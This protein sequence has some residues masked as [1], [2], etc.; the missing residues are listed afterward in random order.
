MS[1]SMET[2]VETNAG[3]VEG[4]QQ[5][6]LCVFKGIPY[7]APPVGE[8]RWLPPAMVEPWSD[9]C[10]AKSSAAICPQS[11]AEGGFL[12]LNQRPEA[13][14]QSEDCLYLNVWTPALD[15]ARR[16][17]MFWIHGGGFTGGSGSSVAYK[18]SRLAARGDVVV[19]T[20]NY[21]LGALGFLNLNELTG[22]KIPATGNEGLQD[23]VAALK[24]VHSNISAFGGNPDNVTIFGESAGGFSVGCLLAVP[25]A[26]GL[27]RR[28]ILQS[29]AA[30]TARTLDKAAQVAE[31]FLDILDVK[32]GDV[33]TLR[34]LPVERLLAAQLEL[35]PRLQKSGMT[36][37]LALQPVI[38]G[39]TLIALPLHAVRDGAAR[40]IPIIV[41]SN[42]DE[43]KM[44]I[45]RDQE[46]QKVDETEL[47]RRV[48]GI[49]PGQNTET[50]VQTYREALLGRG[51]PTTP[52][53]IFTAIRTDQSFR[54]PAVRLA[55]AQYGQGQSAYNYVFTWPSPMLD[56]AMGAHH[57]LELGFLFGNYGEGWGG[58]GPAADA[59]S[60]NIQDAWLAFARNGNP[61][62]ESVG[63]WPPYDE[64]R[65]TMIIR[66]EC[67]VEDAPYDEERRAW[68][69]VPDTL[70]GA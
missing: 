30:N 35:I 47:L 52:A 56:G 69:S 22:G 51:A 37:G 3:K 38:D 48:Q 21:R 20:T 4:Y 6:G 60:R 33:K 40:E 41:G 70:L 32:V 62:C 45:V 1:T 7:A 57:A 17:V 68:D 67:H 44:L 55:E 64:R 54:I 10:P 23:Q 8:R 11:I 46:L 13:E 27:F 39:I 25:Q 2:V 19:V 65:P 43:W 53:E 29:G 15:D 49:L 59:L 24:W 50:M 16:P 63:T 36:G 12:N 58:S 18:G 34:S 5:R 26:K 14:P 66:E 31:Q 28:A 42:L 9:I 61:S